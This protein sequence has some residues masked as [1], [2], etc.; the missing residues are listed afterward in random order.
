M[1]K[2]ALITGSAVSAGQRVRRTLA[3]AG[4]LLTLCGAAIAVT[5]GGGA[6]QA[7]TVL[8]DHDRAE[9]ELA[10][11]AID[12]GRWAAALRHAERAREE[13]PLKAVRWLCH[14][15]GDCPSSFAEI[16]RF[17]EAN[18]TWPRL[19]RLAKRAE[20]LIDGSTPDA[21]IL[22]WF[23]DRAPET[24]AGALQYLAALER[25]GERM[26][27]RT[28]DRARL[29]RAARAVWRTTL[30]GPQDE[31]TF[32][33][34]YRKLVGADDEIE[35]LE[36][37]LWEGHLES[38]ARQA[39]RVPRA[40][41]DL[42]EARIRLRAM[43]GG[44]DA[45]VARVSPRLADHPGLIYERLRWRRKK[46]R[47]ADAIA[48]LQWP[49]MQQVRPD[50]WWRERAILAR[51]AFNEGRI[52]LAYRLAAEHGSS[53]GA[54]FA[55][56]EWFAGWIALRY[57]RDPELAFPH[58]RRMYEGVSFPVSL[59]R[60]AYWAGRAA[61][62]AGQGE[63][64][65]K[66]YLAAARH[67]ANFYGQMA[68]V[69]L[70]AADRPTVPVE[71]DPTALQIA[72]FEAG[73]IPRLIR[74]L[75]AA[76][77]ENTARVF[78]DHFADGL[79][80]PVNFAMLGRLARDAGRPDLSVRVAR[81][82]LKKHVVLS[83]V[84]YPALVLTDSRLSDVS[85]VHG[86][87]RQ[88]SGFDVGA[89]SHA[90]ARGLMQLM[91]ATARNVAR[92]EGL[93]YRPEKLTDDPQFNVRLGTAYLRG[94]LEEYDGYLPMALAAYNAGPSRVA[95]WVEAYGDPRAMPLEEQIDWMESI[96]FRETRNYV[97][98]VLE[99]VT[100][101]RQRAAGRHVA[102]TLVASAR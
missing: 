21:A 66:W 39:R 46:G 93:R 99:G 101:Y 11:R 26:G 36:W 48:L 41:R 76:G 79:T 49:D 87:I 53:E 63:I 28:G 51:G 73:E 19:D 43:R 22:R 20:G 81:E 83:G 89:I 5:A 74:M 88:E 59:S 27:E 8:D 64:A 98:R 13:L 92:A 29:Q 25:M 94:L 6:A 90:G 60:A 35:R 96:P 62:Q 50:L 12:R 45:A 40:Y 67:G 10:F 77:A 2:L 42:A 57:L 84:G 58:F 9:Y 24:G 30:M 68:A 47:D 65:R 17:I 31:R 4:V 78:I 97:Q 61:D 70:P 69:K 75:L 7:R 86:L 54:P 32:R 34:R 18:P 71:P 3:A 33:Q 80:D 14:Q 55:E 95:R 44:V 15:S 82:A 72:A 85:V 102:L 37:L 52:S 56:A 1:R 23:Q 100:V 91:P 38:A 16:T